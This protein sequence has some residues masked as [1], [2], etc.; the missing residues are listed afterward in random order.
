MFDGINFNTAY[1]NGT[2]SNNSKSTSESKKGE[3]HSWFSNNFTFET[4]Y[5]RLNKSG[6]NNFTSF[7]DIVLAQNPSLFG[8]TN[9]FGNANSFENQG[10][11]QGQNPFPN[12]TF[13]AQDYYSNTSSNT[14]ADLPQLKNVYNP[15]AGNKLS[16]IAYQNAREMNQVGRCYAGVKSSLKKAGYDT[17]AL[18]GGSAYMGAEELKKV[19]GLQEVNISRDDIKNLP[20]GS[21]VIYQ[22]SPGHVH[23]HSFIV[24][25]GQDASSAVQGISIRNTGFSA[26]VPC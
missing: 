25:N 10:F 6:A 22:P 5:E 9:Y 1:S 16:A 15:E 20:D 12:A 17:S 3:P 23:G 13:Q 4:F 18:K 24:A 8:N 21:V 7:S 19:K 11:F 14:R 2:T 26:F